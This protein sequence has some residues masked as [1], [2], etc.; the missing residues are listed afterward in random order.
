MEFFFK[1][2]SL[3]GPELVCLLS[4]DGFYEYHNFRNKNLMLHLSVN[5][6]RNPVAEFKKNILEKNYW[7]KESVP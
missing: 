5:S 3:E 2:I 7:P 4:Q 1:I 6:L